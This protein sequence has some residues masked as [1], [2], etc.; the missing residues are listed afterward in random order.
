MQ[1]SLTAT[2][3]PAV[4]LRLPELNA[5]I[6]Q[7]NYV[8]GA[9]PEFLSPATYR[10]LAP[11]RDGNLRS[12][13]MSFLNMHLYGELLVSLLRAR[14]RTFID[15]LGWNLNQTEG[16]EFDQYDTPLCRW[17]VVHE[18]G[19][20]LGGIRLMPTTARNGIY[21]YMLRDA[22]RGLLEGIP[23]D[24]LFFEAPVSATTWEASRLFISED[25]PAQRR[26]HVQSMLMTQLSK[27]AQ[28]MGASHV[29]GIVPAVW[30][31][32]LRRLDLDAVPVG[33]KFAVDRLIS[34][35]ALFNTARH[36]N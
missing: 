18:F 35:A 27:V 8:P 2:A 23:T 19:E 15:H 30:S 7:R 28:D 16:M 13:V 17:V 12:S 11:Q 25:V 1:H 5:P 6:G 10:P 32:W 3:R 31:R 4:K 22:Q 20:V 14:K 33:P 26:L 9:K 21:S 29:I 34:Q 24:V 36:P